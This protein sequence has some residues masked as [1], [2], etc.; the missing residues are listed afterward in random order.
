ML[1]LAMTG[2]GIGQFYL[3][4]GDIDGCFLELWIYFEGKRKLFSSISFQ[5]YLMNISLYLTGVQQWH[6]KYVSQRFL[7]WN[8][9]HFMQNRNL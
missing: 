8:L 6:H 3:C 1:L 9:C 2:P 7:L 5:D 4:H